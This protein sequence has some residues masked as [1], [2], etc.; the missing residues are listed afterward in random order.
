MEQKEE[1]LS[2]I[3]EVSFSSFARTIDALNDMA[4]EAVAGGDNDDRTV[5]DVFVE[6]LIQLPTHYPDDP[7]KAPHKISL[8]GK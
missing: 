7:D 6:W 5:F 3:G 1:R 8:I 4:M 2:Q